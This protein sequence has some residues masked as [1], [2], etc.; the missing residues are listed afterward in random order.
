M[1]NASR[2]DVDHMPAGSQRNCLVEVHDASG[3]LSGAEK[4]GLTAKAEQACNAL[5][6]AGYREVLGG[7][8]LR[9]RCVDDSRPI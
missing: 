6:A 7:G 1:H 3:L 2:H 5:A 4:A 8:S 9:V